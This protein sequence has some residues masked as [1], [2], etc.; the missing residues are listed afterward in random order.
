MGGGGGDG[1]RK[2]REEGQG[3]GVQWGEMRLVRAMREE[4]KGKKNWREVEGGEEF[5]PA[6]INHLR[7]GG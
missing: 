5:S 1:F 6:S 3:L 7:E 4:R 2:W